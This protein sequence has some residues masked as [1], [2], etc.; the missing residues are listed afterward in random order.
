MGSIRA[1]QIADAGLVADRSLSGGRPLSTGTPQA[2]ERLVRVIN[3]GD[4]ACLLSK[5]G[6]FDPSTRSHFMIFYLTFIGT[7]PNCIICS[8]KLDALLGGELLGLPLV[9]DA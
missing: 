9:V 6:W 3:H 7:N 2:S 4:R 8:P 1:Q 5:R